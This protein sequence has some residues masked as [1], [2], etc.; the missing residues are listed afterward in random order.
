MILE[1]LDKVIWQIH[2][3]L[4]H[5]SLPGRL[6][7]LRPHELKRR[8]NFFGSFAGEFDFEAGT[9]GLELV[10]ELKV[11]SEPII[12]ESKSQQAKPFAIAVIVVEGGHVRVL[13][14]AACVLVHL[15][16]RVHV[17]E[18][19]CI[20]PPV[21]RRLHQDSVWLDLF[22]QFLCPLRKHCRRVCR[23]YKVD[24][25]SIESLSQVHQSRIEA[26]IS[27][28]SQKQQDD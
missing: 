3:R 9:Q 22:N 17:L 10:G 13:V 7:K 4:V 18:Q 26:I 19:A 5:H 11:P 23:A 27:E 16:L 21:S 1:P 14:Q 24:I 8:A 12:V 20:V 6:I 2:A 28:Q 15:G 25:L